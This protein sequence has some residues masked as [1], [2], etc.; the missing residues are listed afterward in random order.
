ML[1]SLANAAATSCRCL[2]SGGHPHAD[3]GDYG[4]SAPTTQA[5][6]LAIFD[7]P[8]RGAKGSG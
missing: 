1:R 8:E 3:C 2:R 7:P 6:S 5:R 4:A